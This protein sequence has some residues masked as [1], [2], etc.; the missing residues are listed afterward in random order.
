MI[1]KYTSLI[2]LG[3]ATMVAIPMDLSAQEPSKPKAPVAQA[4]AKVSQKNKPEPVPLVQP[5]QTL[6]DAEGNPE[7]E[8]INPF[9]KGRS[10]EVETD[11]SMGRLQ[12]TTLG[13]VS[14]DF[15]LLAIVVPEDDTVEPM[16]LIRQNQDAGPILVRPGDL[17]RTRE[18]TKRGNRWGRS[19]EE[20]AREKLK[21]NFTFYLYIKNILPTHLEVYHNK[22]NPNETTIITL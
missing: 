20:L 19:K 21:G 11:G 16:A 4:S 5:P 10:R 18:P 3:M 17:I 6:L 14:N 8:L 2:L 12:R 13:E 9:A 15:A 1:S 22:K 7:L